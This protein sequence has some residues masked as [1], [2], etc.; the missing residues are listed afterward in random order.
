MCKVKQSSKIFI[1]GKIKLEEVEKRINKRQHRLACRSPILPLQTIIKTGYNIKKTHT[2][3][4]N[5]LQ[6]TQDMS[7]K[8]PK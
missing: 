8:D 1:K 3:D 2:Q 6:G 5:N 4:F 7:V